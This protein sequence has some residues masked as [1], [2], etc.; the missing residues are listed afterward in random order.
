VEVTNVK[1]FGGRD[2]EGKEK[3]QESAEV[4][5]D[6]AGF[7]ADSLSL[8]FSSK[9]LQVLLDVPLK[10]LEDELVTLKA[11]VKALRQDK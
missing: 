4:I 6:M 1:E 8:E 11:Y 7:I 5:A 10:Q 3:A 2:T 9:Q